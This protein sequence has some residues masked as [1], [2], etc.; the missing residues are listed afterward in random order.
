MGDGFCD[1][2]GAYNSRACSWDGGDCC[3]DSCETTDMY[4]CPDDVMVCEDPTSS[5]YVQPGDRTCEDV[6]SYASWIAD[7]FCDFEGR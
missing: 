2:L 4:S 5:A 7:G 6:V 3:S 1:S